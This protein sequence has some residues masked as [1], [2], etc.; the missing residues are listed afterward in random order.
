[1]FFDPTIFIIIPGI[2][3]ASIAQMKIS[4]AY[5]TYSRI[6][7][8]KGLR[9]AE[10]ARDLLRIAGISDV[11]VE[12]IGGK[13]SDHYDPSKKVVRLSQDIYAGNSIASLS[14]A[15]HEV[16]HAIQHHYGYMPLTIRSSIAPIVGFSSRLSW[17]LI[18]IGLLFGFMSSNVILL[19]IGIILFTVV[20]IFQIITLPV[21][22]NASKRALD[23]LEEYSFLQKNEI[24]GSKKV[25]GAAAL[26]Y[27]AAALTG[28]LQLVRLLVIL[29]GRDD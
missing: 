15:A 4:S 20:V 6:A 11:S 23:M 24:N 25:L 9:G 3:I 7:N 17:V 28:I 1:M 5:G 8:S 12:M 29:N 18:T 19:Q 26:T 27:V 2:I 16:G 21:E 14:V 13:L 10:V 22:F